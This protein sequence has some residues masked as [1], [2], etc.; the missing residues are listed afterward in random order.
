MPDL[1]PSVSAPVRVTSPGGVLKLFE[2]LLAYVDRNIPEEFLITPEGA[3]RTRLITRFGTMGPAFGVVYA[4]FYLLIGHLWGAGIIVL[5]SISM[6]LTPGLMRW[7]K[8][9]ELGGNFFALTLTLGFLSLCFVEGGVHGH[10]LSWLVTVPL[11]ALLVIGRRSS[12]W[13]AII[14]FLAAAIVVGSNLAGWE[15]PKTYDPKIG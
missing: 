8:S 10:A 2:P 14:S 4:L 9:P 15:L 13:W 7:K 5:C 1:P 12:F 3:R 11:C 6:W